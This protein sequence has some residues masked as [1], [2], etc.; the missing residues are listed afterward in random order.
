MRPR[1]AGEH[2][3]LEFA[4]RSGALDEMQHDPH[5]SESWEGTKHFD[6]QRSISGAELDE[7]PHPPWTEVL[8]STPGG[9]GRDRRS[10]RRVESGCR[11]EIAAAAD[12]A[13]P[14]G[15]GTEARMVERAL[16]PGLE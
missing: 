5:P 16:H 4:H 14:A 1:Q 15:V 3:L 2:F 13:D 12:V 9:P 11:R 7:M 6:S 10:E 8:T